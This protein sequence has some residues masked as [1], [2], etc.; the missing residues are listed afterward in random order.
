MMYD[1]ILPYQQVYRNDSD[2]GK[3]PSVKPAKEFHLIWRHNGRSPVTMWEPLPPAGYRAIGTVLVPDAEQPGSN[4][5]LCVRE[6]LCTQTGT[7][8]SAVWKYEPSV[9]QVR[10]SAHLRDF[11][12]LILVFAVPGSNCCCCG[13]VMSEWC[14]ACIT[15]QIAEVYSCMQIQCP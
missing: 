10:P 12:Q 3:Q 8:D 11:L 2:K 1:S 14:D 15:A 9:V 4:E 6:D 13:L 7:F 5:V